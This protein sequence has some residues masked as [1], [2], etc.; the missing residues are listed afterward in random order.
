MSDRKEAIERLAEVKL[1]GGAYA[2]SFA[3]LSAVC[4]AVYDPPFGWTLGA[5]ATLRDRLIAL[6]GAAEE[7]IGE[8][9][10][11]ET[12]KLEADVQGMCAELEERAAS[13]LLWACAALQ[14]ELDA[15]KAKYATMGN[16]LRQTKASRDRWKSEAEELRADRDKLAEETHMWESKLR[17]CNTER[18]CCKEERDS[19][20]AKLREIVEDGCSS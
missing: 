15:L 18:L 12:P 17:D 5:V 3:N 2:D 10:A 8:P 13:K 7:P 1:D 4:K 20:M 11:R 14:D 19:L 6:L 9:D 16:D